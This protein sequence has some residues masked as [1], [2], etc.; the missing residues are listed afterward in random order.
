MVEVIE[1]PSVEPSD[2]AT[3]FWRLGT[4]GGI[5]VCR[6]LMMRHIQVYE[7]SVPPSAA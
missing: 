2:W 4:M 5:R 1:E 6:K 3:R 7:L